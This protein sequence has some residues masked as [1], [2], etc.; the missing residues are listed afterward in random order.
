MFTSLHGCAFILSKLIILFFSNIS[1]NFLKS[2]LYCQHRWLFGLLIWLFLMTGHYSTCLINS[3]KL[4]IVC[5]IYT[6]RNCYVFQEFHNLQNL[7][8]QD[9]YRCLAGPGTLQ[10]IARYP[11]E[12]NDVLQ[13][14]LPGKPTITSI[15]IFS[16][17]FHPFTTTTTTTTTTSVQTPSGG[18]LHYPLII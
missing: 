5:D 9:I 17:S 2:A 11:A 1:L 14:T 6:H 4:T 16:H 8:L 18:Y 13:D 10:G 3:K 15:Q 7:V 12:Y